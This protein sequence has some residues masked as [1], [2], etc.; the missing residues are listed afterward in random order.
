[1]ELYIVY[2]H[3]KRL[4]DMARLDATIVGLNEAEL[5]KNG[6]ANLDEKLPISQHRQAILDAI[7]SNT[8]VLVHGATGSGK[9]TQIPQYILDAGIRKGD[10]PCIIV[11]QPRRIAAISIARH[12][13]HER[14]WELG[15]LVGYRI[16]QDSAA[17]QQTR[18]LYCTQGVFLEM[19]KDRSGLS[20]ITHVILDE[21]HEREEE[22]DLAL[23]LM[24]KLVLDVVSPPSIK[25]IVMSATMDME[26]FSTYLKNPPVIAIHTGMYKVE[27]YYLGDIGHE[28]RESLAYC[29]SK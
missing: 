28:V 26:K 16:A 19:L 24:K 4:G 9:T 8:V 27:E 22:M 7:E 13:C 10:L 1:M 17:S 23:L 2:I 3:C 12:I 21:M 15:G 6:I 5:Y 11:T 20:R 18:I 25:L 29:S 14:K